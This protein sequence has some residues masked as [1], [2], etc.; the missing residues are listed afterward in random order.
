MIPGVHVS[1]SEGRSVRPL[2]RLLLLI[3][4]ALGLAL[5]TGPVPTAGAAPG[6]GG[7]AVNRAEAR[8]AKAVRHHRLAT[9]RK[10]SA[11]RTRTAAVRRATDARA[12]HEN[13]AHAHQQ[14]VDARGH[15]FEQARQARLA[16]DEAYRHLDHMQREHADAE[17]RIR[18]LTRAMDAERARWNGCVND[19][20][21][22]FRCR[23]GNGDWVPNNELDR[24][25]LARAA[26][27]D[28]A[29]RWAGEVANARTVVGHRTH[30][31]AACDQQAREADA[32]AAGTGVTLTDAARAHEAAVTDQGIA[33]QRLV[34]AQRAVVKAKTALV[35]ARK[36][37]RKVR[38]RHR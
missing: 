18:D 17:Y 12:A 30:V 28:Q 11:A 19:G 34:A 10:A 31:V 1:L 32:R 29:A 4:L 2:S 23:R 8:V 38:A 37:L 13:A 3:S 26:T 7:D 15:V 25:Y 33:A 16:L 36:H 6:R 14:A 22:R 27:Q 21:P 9:H 5:V 35:K 20:A 24:L